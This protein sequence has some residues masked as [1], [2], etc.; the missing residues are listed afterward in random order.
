MNAQIIEEKAVNNVAREP[1]IEKFLMAGL[2]CEAESV[3]IIH[4]LLF[5]QQLSCLHWTCYFVT[6]AFHIEFK[7]CTQTSNIN[8]NQR[9]SVGPPSTYIKLER[10]A[11]SFTHWHILW[12]TSRCLTT[13]ILYWNENSWSQTYGI[14][15][16]S[17]I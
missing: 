12:D 10:V 6:L 2:I 14:N 1:Y 8:I 16:K 11:H 4:V 17:L 9:L 3:C 15:S 7:R 5:F 13:W